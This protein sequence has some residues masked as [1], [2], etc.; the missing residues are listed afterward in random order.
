GGG[1]GAWGGRVGRRAR[2][3][4]Q[5]GAVLADPTQMQQVLLNLCTNAAH[6]MRETGGVLEVRVEAGDDPA[7]QA[8][9]PG[10]FLSGPSLRLTV[11]DTGHGM[12]P[13]I[14]EHIFEPF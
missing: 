7:A 3:G 10:P 11:R 14:L 2:R 8:P 1:G 12:T 4:G 6:A 13:D 9:G 5:A